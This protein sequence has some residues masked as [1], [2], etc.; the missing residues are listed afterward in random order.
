MQRDRLTLHVS[1]KTMLADIHT[2]QTTRLQVTPDLLRHIAHR[3][4]FKADRIE[5]GDIK[6]AYTLEGGGSVIEFCVGNV[7]EDNFKKWQLCDYK[8]SI[9]GDMDAFQACL[10]DG[11]TLLCEAKGTSPEDALANLKEKSQ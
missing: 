8:I 1:L 3:L 9:T 5:V 6:T 11:N 4:E 10:Y 7:G 2:F